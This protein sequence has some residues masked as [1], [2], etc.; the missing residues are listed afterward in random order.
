MYVSKYSSMDEHFQLVE[1]VLPDR[2]DEAGGWGWDSP[3]LVSPVVVWRTLR[4]LAIAGDR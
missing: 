2:E 4:A 1:P 3:V